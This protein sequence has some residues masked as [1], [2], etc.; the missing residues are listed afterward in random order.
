MKTS[1]YLQKYQP[2][3][4]RIFL[5]ALTDDIFFH[6]YLL[7]S[8]KGSSLLKVAK[9]LVKSLNCEERDPFACEKCITCERI[10]QN[11]Y[12]AL[13]I[14]D[15]KK[16]VKINDLRTKIEDAFSVTSNEKNAKRVYIILN[17]EYLT[18]E[19]INFLLKF[20][21]EPP[22][23]TFAI[24]TTENEMQV[25]PTILSR[26]QIIRF[27]E[28]DRKYFIERAKNEALPLSDVSLLSNFYNDFDEIK[29]E[30]NSELYIKVKNLVFH[31]L[32]N[33]DNP[34]KARYIVEKD[35][36]K[37]LNDK[38]SLYY[39][40]DFLIILFKEALKI[41]LHEK[42]NLIDYEKKLIKINDNIKNIAEKLKFLMEEENLIN[43][44]LNGSLL[45]IHS[46]TSILEEK[47]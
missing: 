30:I 24:F 47:L 11:N 36:V 46:L 40:Y 33:I 28:I 32:D 27:K 29:N 15:A 1:E 38:E 37:Q 9:F 44:N 26:T 6:A 21:E 7:S 34:L 20:L 13:V 18:R 45:L 19:C 5:N 10:E 3:P 23:D 8:P 35:I 39:F 31:Y 25:I 16:G 2:I 17:I 4:Y 12:N 41:S 42:P 43:K 22:K 14:L